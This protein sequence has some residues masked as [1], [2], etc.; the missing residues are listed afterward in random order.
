MIY[1]Y[2][3]EIVNLFIIIIILIYIKIANIIDYSFV[4]KNNLYLV[5]EYI[6]GGDIFTLLQNV[7]C[8]SEENARIY[9]V[10]IVK[11]LQFLRING[12]VHRDIKPDN[13]LITA[14]GRLK[15]ADFGL[16]Y[17]GVANQRLS[18]ANSTNLKM[19]RAKKKGKEFGKMRHNSLP[20]NETQPASTEPKAPSILSDPTLSVLLDL[21]ISDQSIPLIGITSSN[22]SNDQRIGA[23]LSTESY[24]N[25]N[26][27]SVSN[28]SSDLSNNSNNNNNVNISSLSSISADSILSSN[29]ISPTNSANA[30]VGTPDYMAPEIIKSKNHTYTADYWSLGCVVFEMLTGIP[31]FHGVDEVDTF[32]RILV[33]AGFWEELND[34]EVSEEAKDFIHKLLTVDPLLR[35]GSKNI[36]E[37]MRHPWFKEIDWDKVEALEP[38]FVPDTSSLDNYKNYF[39]TRYSFSQRDENDIIEDMEESASERSNQPP[40]LIAGTSSSINLSLTPTF[41]SNSNSLIAAEVSEGSSNMNN[42][43]SAISSNSSSTNLKLMHNE[44][45]KKSRNKNEDEIEG[46]LTS[47]P[48]ISF[49]HLKDT[50]VEIAQRIRQEKR[51]KSEISSLKA[52]PSDDMVQ[53]QPPLKR[54]SN[55]VSSP[56]IRKQTHQEEESGEPS[57]NTE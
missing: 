1:N 11:A 5:M 36:D 37:I 50:N 28:L 12:I 21:S 38:V 2:R 51:R 54:N 4:E 7:G 3:F 34:A 45:F 39:S 15:L 30:V 44:F 10:Q 14:Q 49:E 16:S 53:K 56:L 23:D 47:F 25:I 57:T 55:F 9:T 22:E 32:R 41:A 33:G 40:S 24:T 27:S 8:L 35:L 52:M 6:P 17:F 20:D 42:S 29:S 43:I 48:T 46:E 13:I 31:P 26:S 18:A 19:R